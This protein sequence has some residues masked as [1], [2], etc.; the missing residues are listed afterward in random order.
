MPRK[1]KVYVLSHKSLDLREVR[2]FWPKLL[3]GSV[4]IGLVVVAVL[5]LLN[6]FGGDM[7]GLGFDRM[8][9]LTAEN[10]I[11]KEELRSFAD[12]MGVVQKALDRLAD[13]GNELRTAVDLRRID[14][15]TRAAATGG[16]VPPAAGSFLSGEAREVLDGSADLLDK[17]ER[18]VKLQQSSYEEVTHRMEYNKGLF[19]HIPAIKP[20]SGVYSIN[21]F[22]MRIHPVLRVYRMH[23]GV[24]IIG[25]VGTNVYAAGDGTVRFAGRTAGGY[26][27]VVEVSHGYGYSSLYAH[28][29]RALVREGQTVKRGELI[30]KSGRSGLVSGPHL[31]YEVRY[32]GR[33]HNPIDYFFDDIDAARY[34]SQL[35]NARTA[36][37]EH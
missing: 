3:G 36:R 16:A 18:E 25:D 28:L 33:K 32:Q 2:H 23:E 13:R 17:L 14:D 20:M 27:V 21:G 6:H 5:L 26:G 8:S 34:R 11:L 30:A 10:K 12:K 4:V 7:L 31:H 1:S 22:G 9:M 15:D 37:G 19:T 35:A 29:S 24:D